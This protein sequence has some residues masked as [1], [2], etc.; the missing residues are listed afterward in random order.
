MKKNFTKRVA[1]L[2]ATIAAV[3][4]KGFMPIVWCPDEARLLVKKSTER[5][6][7]NRVVL[8]VSEIATDIN[9]KIEGEVK[10]EN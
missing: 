5:E 7:P 9:V 2:S 1:A 6:M 4:E 3:Q 10:V 8:S